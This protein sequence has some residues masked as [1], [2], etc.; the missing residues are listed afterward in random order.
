MALSDRYG[1][2]LSTGS[3]AARDFYAAGVDHI[4]AATHGAVE[5]FEGATEADPG[6]ALGHAGLAR[7]RMYAGDMAGAQAAIAQA[8]ALSNDAS[9]REQQHIE[10]LSLLLSGK[11]AAARDLVLAHVRDYPRD[12]LCAQICTNVFGLIGFSGH[13]G[14]EAELLAYT[15]ALMPHYGED[16]WMQSMHALSLCEVGE[17]AASLDLMERS[18]TANPHNANGSHFKAHA[19]YEDGQAEAGL[20]YL[21]SWMESYD[22]RAV[23]HGHLSWHM[24]LWALHLGQVDR[25]WALIDSGIAP[26]GAKGLPINILTDTAAIYHR[27]SLTGISI[28][29]ERWKAMSDYAAR[30][31]PATGQSFADIHSALCHAMAGEPDRLMQFSQ[32]PNGFAADLVAPVAETWAAI[33]RQDWSAALAQLGPVMASHVR[34]GGSR[35][36]RDLLELTYVNLL[37]RLGQR[38]EARRAMQGRRPI[39]A[40]TAPVAGYA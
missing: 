9:H 30:F 23:L 28:A 35:A 26:G 25:M 20:D 7:A 22:S 13:A 14:R 11:A 18:L 40:E 6:F 8:S 27:A 33:A 1:N 39:F 10:S 38:D 21:E 2:A 37:L 15:S 31:F 4:L 12:A 32:S 19:Q 5:S 29:P 17:T 36:Q 24:A 3:D 16:W 34:V